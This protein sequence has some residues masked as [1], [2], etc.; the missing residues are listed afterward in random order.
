MGQDLQKVLAELYPTMSPNLDP[1]L[2]A[3]SVTSTPV[4]TLPTLP[5]VT[6]PFVYVTPMPAPKS[7]PAPTPAPMSVPTPTPKPIITTHV[8]TH[9]IHVTAGSDGHL[10]VILSS[11]LGSALLVLAFVI[12][13][14][15][16][17]ERVRRLS[18]YGDSRQLTWRLEYS[19]DSDV[20][21]ASGTD[22]DV[23]APFNSQYSGNY[24]SNTFCVW[25]GR[26]DRC[27]SHCEGS[28]SNSH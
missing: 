1:I 14:L 9:Q 15:Y 27:G 11:S 13:A 24:K 17:F 3:A 4:P 10:V 12:L 2:K 22:T 6:I 16:W 21:E 26:G 23:T 8:P 28:K 20:A 18:S 5:T 25:G 19:F 7:T